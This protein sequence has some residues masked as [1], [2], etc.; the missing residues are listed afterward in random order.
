MDSEEEKRGRSGAKETSRDG[1]VEGIVVETKFEG[2]NSR[3][4]RARN[5]ARRNR[6]R[7]TIV[8]K[9]ESGI[10]ETSGGSEGGQE[11][12][13]GA[14]E[15]VGTGIKGQASQTS[16]GRDGLEEVGSD[17]T[18]ELVSADVDENSVDRG[19]SREREERG[20][21]GTG[22]T[23]VVEGDGDESSVVEAGRSEGRNRTNQTIVGQVENE[24]LSVT[25]IVQQ[26]G[27][28]GTTDSV[29]RE[30]ESGNR[31]GQSGRKRS[32]KLAVSDGHS[33]DRRL[34]SEEAIPADEICGRGGRSGREIAED[35]ILE[36][37]ISKVSSESQKRINDGSRTRDDD[38]V[39]LE[40]GNVLS[41]VPEAL[42][43]DE[44]SSVF[45]GA[46]V[47]RLVA[48]SLQSI[49]QSVFKGGISGRSFG[50]EENRGVSLVGG[51]LHK[52][53]SLKPLNAMYQD[54]TTQMG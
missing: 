8:G 33:L 11:G 5:D 7:K 17:I 31:S 24:L 39:G 30:I 21:Q 52:I 28:D 26:S 9:D 1:T 34:G 10:S 2:L 43:K 23:V 38:I 37:E 49:T 41:Q 20:G 25:C 54:N 22:E 35:N 53:A 50:S 19:E 32:S 6:T 27:G 29:V 51:L 18:R 48:N 13:D 46:N 40:G 3:E 14:V 42:R 47:D 36:E 15:S 12:R 16:R 45:V 44:K 4:R